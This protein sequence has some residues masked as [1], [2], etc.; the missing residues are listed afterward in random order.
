MPLF[1]AIV[2]SA[3]FDSGDKYLIVM[4]NLY[5]FISE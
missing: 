1:H 5:L 3:Y 2:E 4:A